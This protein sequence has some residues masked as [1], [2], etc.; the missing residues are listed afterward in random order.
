MANDGKGKPNTNR[1]QWFINTVKTQWLDGKNI[2][3]G[4][5]LS[6]KDVIKSIEKRG[7][8]GGTPNALIIIEDSG[9]MPSQPEDSIPTMVS[10]P[11]TA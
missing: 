11:L 6:G 4:M 9:S 5:V 3:F 2:I 1:S 10:Q 8:N 7:T